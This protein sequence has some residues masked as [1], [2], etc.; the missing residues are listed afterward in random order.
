MDEII[1]IKCPFCGAVL[2][3]K[4]QPGIESKNVT[5]PICKKKYLFSEF[6][7]VNENFNAGGDTEYPGGGDEP[8]SLA[9]GG[10]SQPSDGPNFTLGKLIV[11]GT[12]LSFQLKPGKNVVGRKAHKSEADIQIDTGDGRFMS[13]EHLVIDVKKYPGKGF[14]HYVSLY[15]EKVNKTC[16]GNNQLYYG[17]CIVLNDGDFIH[18]PDVE[19]KFVIPD[20]DATQ[21]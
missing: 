10:A 6:K 20:D 13:R 8:T 3:V 4:D 9:F 17:D 21:I 14:V 2:S 1:Q 18:M 7:K 19:L 11:Q 12:A 5:C 16:I 15:K